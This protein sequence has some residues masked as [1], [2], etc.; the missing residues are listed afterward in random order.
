MPRVATLL[1]G[2]LAGMVTGWMLLA[3]PIAA[4]F[5]PTTV[6]WD[7]TGCPFGV[8]TVTATATSLADGTAYLTTPTKVLL[9][10]KTLSQQFPNLPPGEYSVTATLQSPRGRILKS[11]VQTV[12]GQGRGPGRPRPPVRIP[13]GLARPRGGTS[14]TQPLSQA[15]QST[16]AD[17]VA[18]PSATTQI[19]TNRDAVT[20][21]TRPLVLPRELLR[22]LAQLSVIVDPM[23][24]ESGWRAI[25]LADLDGD[26]TIDA[27]TI[28]LSSGVTFQWVR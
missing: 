20:S 14:P 3:S 19:D 25:E 1:A 12:R 6:T 22:L 17:P 11:A 21:T 8:F 26:G 5:G 9:P 10:R 18:T 7:A 27:A 28:E 13:T 16:L 2:L 4:Y 23:E 24:T 15:P